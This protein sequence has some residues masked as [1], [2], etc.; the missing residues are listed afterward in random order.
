MAESQKL[1]INIP[2][3]GFY[4]SLYS[5][6]IDR[7]E[8][9]DAQHLADQQ[10]EDGT[11]EE[12]RL[13]ADDFAGI[14]MDVTDYG[15]VHNAV[16]KTYVQ[17]FNRLWSDAIGVPLGL[18]FETMK[19]PREYNFT[20][21]RIFTYI[22]FA[23]VQKLFERSTLDGHATLAAEIKDRFTSRDGFSSYYRTALDSW[24]AKPLE[25][26]DHNELGTLLIAAFKLSPDYSKDWRNDVYD[27][28]TDCDGFYQEWT[29][30]VDW[31]KF[32]GKVKEARAYLEAE[33]RA[34]DPDYVPPLQRCKN[35]PDLFTS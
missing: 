17:V 28:A 29:E 9:N 20:T 32:E 18:E 25:D 8:E 23:V 6:E 22:E 14:F 26:W 5:Y 15:A 21:D 35:T 2:F 1:I 34:D 30:G 3:D 11:P 12:L 19:S 13:T 33:L 24:L 31:E 27:A 16:A 10:K 7:N 4:E